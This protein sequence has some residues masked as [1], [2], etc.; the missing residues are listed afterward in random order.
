MS[1]YLKWTCTDRKAHRAAGAWIVTD[2]HCAYSAFNGYHYSSS[3]YCAVKCLI[4]GRTW[5]TKAKY[6]DSLRRGTREEALKP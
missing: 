2:D 3:D 5:R 6:V 4:C 1:H